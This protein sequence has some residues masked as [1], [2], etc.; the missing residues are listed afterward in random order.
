MSEEY[1]KWIDELREQ[2]QVLSLIEVKSPE[3]FAPV[4]GGM[5]L[6]L[7]VIYRD[8]TKWTVLNLNMDGMRVQVRFVSLAQLEE[9]V[10]KR[11]DKNLITWLQEGEVLVDKQDKI[12]TLKTAFFEL[13]Q[14][15]YE[16]KL[17]VEFALFLN[18]YMESKQY[19]KLDH[20]L[21]SFNSVLQAIHHWARIQII[22]HGMVPELTVWKQVKSIDP[23][24]Y[25]LYEELVSTEEPLNKR[26]ELVLLASEFSVL[27]EIEHSTRFLVSIIKEREEPWGIEELM[28]HPRLKDHSL[29]LT[30]VLEKMVNRSLIKAVSVPLDDERER[31][32]ISKKW[33]NLHVRKYTV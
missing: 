22:K 1:K 10:F 17:F 28:N 5:D 18:K 12:E 14:D 3:L 30:L 25:K 19:L 6:L 16:Q 2:E 32:D 24:I 23:A 21:D 4:A 29:D 11:L 27:S 13:T 9:A 8:E 15:I 7:L 26:I 31:D 20:D 33:R